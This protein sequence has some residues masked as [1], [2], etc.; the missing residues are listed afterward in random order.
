MT[1]NYCEKIIKNKKV[2]IGLNDVPEM[3]RTTQLRQNYV[4]MLDVLVMNWIFTSKWNAAQFFTALKPLKWEWNRWEYLNIYICWICGIEWKQIII[5]IMIIPV[6][7]LS[8]HFASVRSFVRNFNWIS[9][10]LENIMIRRHRAW[11]P[12]TENTW[13]FIFSQPFAFRQASYCSRR[14]AFIHSFSSFFPYCLKRIHA[15]HRP[16]IIVITC[17]QKAA[18]VASVVKRWRYLCFRVPKVLPKKRS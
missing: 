9:S 4:R 16:R 1:T 7:W 12:N 18:A 11:S 17:R 8:D 15:A 14:Q 2:H 3:R 6:F 10:T 5:I 13:K